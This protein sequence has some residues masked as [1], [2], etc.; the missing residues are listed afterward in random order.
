LRLAL[1]EHAR[2]SQCAFCHGPLSAASEE[3]A[4]CRSCA[5]VYHQDCALEAGRCATFGCG[6]ALA[7]ARLC[8]TCSRPII[9][10]ENSWSCLS[11]KQIRHLECARARACVCGAAVL[12]PAEPRILREI[13]S[14]GLGPAFHQFFRL[15]TYSALI[16]LAVLFVVAYIESRHR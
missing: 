4:A 11:C 14:L 13:T 10:N 1:H 5:A 3:V 15:L 6:A 12:P 16:A 2:P 7:G 9:V 8:P